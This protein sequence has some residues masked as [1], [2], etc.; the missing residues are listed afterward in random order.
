MSTTHIHNPLVI[1]C[2]FH[3]LALSGKTPFESENVKYRSGL[4]DYENN[5]FAIP[6]GQAT[7][8]RTAEP[9]YLYLQQCHIKSWEEKEG[10]GGVGWNARS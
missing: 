8:F 4:T 1:K 2:I 5:A 7:V 9:Q 3:K 6:Y 10:K